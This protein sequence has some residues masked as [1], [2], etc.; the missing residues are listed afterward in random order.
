MSHRSEVGR[1]LII[2]DN[3]KRLLFASINKVHYFYITI[4]DH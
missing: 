4:E 3:G 2:V 1:E